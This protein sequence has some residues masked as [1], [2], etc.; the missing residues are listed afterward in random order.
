MSIDCSTRKE[1]G[2]KNK[3][4]VWTGSTEGVRA[5]HRTRETERARERERDNT[6]LHPTS[7]NV[8]FVT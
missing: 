4:A 3:A 2:H 7:Y 5:M 1:N 8:A 6:A